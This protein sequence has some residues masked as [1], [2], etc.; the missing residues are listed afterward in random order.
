MGPLLKV[1]IENESGLLVLWVSCGIII[2]EAADFYSTPMRRRQK[3]ESLPIGFFSGF[4]GAL[5]QPMLQKTN[6]V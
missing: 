1:Q 2:S 5:S 4:I 6:S 3:M